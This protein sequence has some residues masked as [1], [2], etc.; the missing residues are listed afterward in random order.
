[1][2]DSTGTGTP[3]T[4]LVRDSFTLLSLLLFLL[5]FL[6]LVQELHAVPPLC[7]AKAF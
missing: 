7:G 1:M 6:A 3:V 4:L 5:N 2:L